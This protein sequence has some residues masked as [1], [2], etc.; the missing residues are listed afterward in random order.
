[1]IEKGLN[2][3]QIDKDIDYLRNVLGGNKGA[4]QN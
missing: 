4:K 3:E 2:I 1:M